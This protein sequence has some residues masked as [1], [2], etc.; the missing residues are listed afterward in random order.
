MLPAVPLTSL[1]RERIIES[2]GDYS[3]TITGRTLIASW[4]L[5][6][7]LSIGRRNDFP[8]SLVNLLV[9][10][11]LSGWSIQAFGPK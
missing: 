5:F 4:L 7:L 10:N 3:I 8:S 2:G 9:N 1:V 6:S 11:M